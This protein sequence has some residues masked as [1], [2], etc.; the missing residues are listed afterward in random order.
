[1]HVFVG[2]I[3]MSTL[4]IVAFRIKLG[5][6]KSMIVEIAVLYWHFVD[7]VWIVIFTVVYLIQR[8][9]AA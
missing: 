4:L 3:W 6:D 1:M 5:P 9:P 2:V 7:V 8:G